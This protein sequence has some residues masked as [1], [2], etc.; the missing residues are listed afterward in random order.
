MACVDMPA[1]APVCDCPPECE[2]GVIWIPCWHVPTC[3]E[4][5]D[6]FEAAAHCLSACH[7]EPGAS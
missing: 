5:Q 7:T 3:D 6:G 1:V 2:A 4:A